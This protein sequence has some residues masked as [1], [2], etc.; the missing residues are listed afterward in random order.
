MSE[1]KEYI[2]IEKYRP[3]TVEDIVF[4]EK[5]K[6]KNYLK[7]TSSI[8]HFL[9][10]SK[11]PGTGKT[12]LALA[13]I[14]ELNCDK[15]LLNSSD[16]RNLETIRE[17]V[18]IF[19]RAKSIKQGL[20]KCVFMDEFDGMTSTSQNALRNIME[21][22]ANN[23]FFILTCNN[24]EKVIAPIQSRCVKMEFSNP[25]KIKIYA[26]LKNICEKEK[27]EYEEVGLKYLVF[28]NYPNIRNMVMLLQDFKVAGKKVTQENTIKNEKYLPAYSLI[29]EKKILELRKLIYAGKVDVVE[30]N[31]W[32]FRKILQEANIN[33]LNK[34]KEVAIVLADNEKAFTQGANPDIIFLASVFQIMEYI[35]G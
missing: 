34:L 1:L 2:F 21:T 11:S 35:N 19:A 8:P 20:K 29:K 23:C 10:A 4:N 16:D 28:N 6:I 13:I 15:L 18:K 5:N 3:R 30:F 26:Y 31:N 22:Y 24:A 25:D 12:S 17:K 32:L 9:F 27:I 14:N 33:N 7:N